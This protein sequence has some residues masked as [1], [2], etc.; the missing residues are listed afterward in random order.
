MH[1][2]KLD[3][4]V[5]EARARPV[6]ERP[7]IPVSAPRAS[8]VRLDVTHIQ[9]GAARVDTVVCDLTRDPRSEDFAADRPREPI[10]TPPPPRFDWD[11]FAFSDGT[12][13]VDGADAEEDDVAHNHSIMRPVRR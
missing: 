5:A 8:R 13:L 6:S 3:R 9:C 1:A 10:K 11:T 12:L 4:D 2:A 7:T